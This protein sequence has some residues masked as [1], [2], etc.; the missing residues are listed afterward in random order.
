[1]Q[2]W[3]QH[4]LDNP[5]EDQQLVVDDGLLCLQQRGGQWFALAELTVSATLDEAFLAR[6][7][8]LS[9]PALRYFGRDA[10]ALALQDNRLVLLLSLHAADAD[11]VCER[12]ALLLNQRDVWQTLLLQQRK[13]AVTHGT[14]PLHSLAFLPRG[15]HG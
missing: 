15:N 4:W 5:G 11:T 12:L 14:V 9:A 7:L 3:V 1:M 2:H 10:A 8:Q 6:A 13:K